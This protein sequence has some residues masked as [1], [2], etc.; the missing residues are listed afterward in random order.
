MRQVTL[1][2]HATVLIQFEQ[3]YFITDPIFSSHVVFIP[4]IHPPGLWIGQLSPLAAVLISHG[5]YNH[6]DFKSLR[7]L[8]TSTTVVIPA[9][10]EQYVRQ[11]GFTDVRMFKPWQTTEIEGVGVTAVPAKHFGGRPFFH[12]HGYFYTNLMKEKDKRS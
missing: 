9:G 10:L 7:L 8:S 6:F 12:K 1:I 11:Y 5:H 4:R 2:G 3:I